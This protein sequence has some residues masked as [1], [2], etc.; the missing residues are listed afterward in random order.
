MKGLIGR[1]LGMT[2]VF[3]PDGEVV[4]VTVVE[5]TGNKVLQIKTI[6]RDGYEAIQ[7]G[8]GRK[9]LHR[10]TRA[11]RTRAEAAGLDSAPQRIREFRTPDAS[12]F[13]VGDEIKVDFFQPGDRVK[14][15]GTSKGRGFAGAIK[16]HG[17]A[18]GTRASHGGGPSH[19]GVGS[20]GMSADP[21]RTMKGRK[22]AG[23]YGNKKTTAMNLLVVSVDPEEELVLV[24]GSV[25]GP[26]NGLVTIELVGE[27]PRTYQQAADEEA[28][29]TVEDLPEEGEADPAVAE[30]EE[31]DAS[32]EEE[33]VE[34][35]S[36]ST[37]ETEEESEE[38]E[39]EKSE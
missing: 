30:T 21:A 5:V 1:K 33:A 6:E 24:R 32:A 11:N 16:R 4:P 31:T 22:L 36:D 39:E 17:F 3:G 23:Q 27:Q 37:E 12:R 19:R 2:Q 38:L 10:A 34:A 15:R 8:Y 20:V 29:E 14:I 35:E 18:G 9:K 7:V 26:M 13:K 25:P 28:L